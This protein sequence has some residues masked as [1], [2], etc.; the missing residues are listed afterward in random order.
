MKVHTCTWFHFA[1]GLLQA[2]RNNHFC[3]ELQGKISC[4]QNKNLHAT[5]Q[6]CVALC[7]HICRPLHAQ[8]CPIHVY[9]WTHALTWKTPKFVCRCTILTAF[10]ILLGAFTQWHASQKLPG[11]LVQKI[12]YTY[13]VASDRW[14]YWVLM[15]NSNLKLCVYAYVCLCVGGRGAWDFKFLHAADIHVERNFKKHC[16]SRT[17]FT[18]QVW[19]LSSQMRFHVHND[20]WN[21]NYFT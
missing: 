20:I 7:V 10:S 1:F 9:N 18:E 13:A 4:C 3:N 2:Q 17:L 11:L 21:L 19:K 12:V 14:V 15:M 16:K 5:L 8:A 6:L